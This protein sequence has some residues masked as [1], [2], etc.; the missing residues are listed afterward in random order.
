MLRAAVWGFLGIFLALPAAA[1]ERPALWGFIHEVKIGAQVHDVPYMW[2]GFN[3][4]PYSVDL[5]IEMLLAPSVALWGGRLRP[6]IGAT[7]NFEGYTSKAYIDARWQRELSRSIFYALGIGLAV[8]DGESF[9]SDPDRKQ[10][11]RSWLFH[12]NA[13]VGYRL[14]E[15][16]SV[17][18]YYEHISNASTAPKNHGLDTLGVRYGYRF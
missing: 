17:S 3:R 13:E 1:G 9:T 11:G 15:H 2:S 16:Q 6:A 8:H 12:P 18:I 5:N 4:E 7:I 10:L 14:N